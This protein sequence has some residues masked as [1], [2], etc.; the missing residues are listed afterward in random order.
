MSLRAMSSVRV[1]RCERLRREDDA[2]S[3]LQRLG[4][5]TLLMMELDMLDRRVEA[6]WLLRLTANIHNI[7]DCCAV[8]FKCLDEGLFEEQQ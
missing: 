5:V 2:V 1:T 7:R 6:L 4:T 8:R 3:T